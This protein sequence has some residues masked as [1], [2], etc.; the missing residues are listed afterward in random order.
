VLIPRREVAD[1]VRAR[2]RKG[3][4]SLLEDLAADVAGW[5]ARAVEFYRLL[6]V[7][8]NLNHLRPDRG[9]VADLHDTER[10]YRIG[11]PF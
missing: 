7:F 11:G 1:V 5:P 9:V 8:Q 3:T 2:R 6:A 10:L 4:L